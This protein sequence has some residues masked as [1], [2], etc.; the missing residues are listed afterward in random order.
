MITLILAPCLHG[1]KLGRGGTNAVLVIV[2]HN[3]EDQK[4]FVAHQVTS[5]CVD[6]EA[7]SL[8]FVPLLH[9]LR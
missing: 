3:V 6:D 4:N 1:D 7:T 8:I 2:T 5:G 9:K